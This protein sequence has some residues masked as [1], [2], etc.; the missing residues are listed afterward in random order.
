[1]TRRISSHRFSLLLAALL[2]L[3]ITTPAVALLQARGHEALSYNLITLLLALVVVAAAIAVGES[4]ATI[5]LALVLAGPA[6]L[7]AASDALLHHDVLA[8]A[9]RLCRTLFLLF[10]VY[11]LL[12]YVL[13]AERVTQNTISAALCVYLLLGVAW[14]TS[15]VLIERVEPASFSVTLQGDTS[16]RSSWTQA[17]WSIEM[18]YY[19]FTTLT[20]LGYGDV[21]PLSPLARMLSVTEAVVG[22]IFLVVLVARLVGLHVAQLANSNARSDKTG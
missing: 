6:V 1:M 7:L 11:L 15:Y 16:S 10:A 22:Q 14:S 9:H 17:E 12:R 21:V 8:F 2:L 4:R 19:S 13:T 5:R 3:L 18:L 20:T